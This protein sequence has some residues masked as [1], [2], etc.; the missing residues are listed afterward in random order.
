MTVY[1][2]RQKNESITS[3]VSVFVKCRAILNKLLCQKLNKA[4]E[5]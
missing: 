4:L 2:N 3:I 1:K 5:F